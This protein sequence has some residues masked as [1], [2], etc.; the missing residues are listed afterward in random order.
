MVGG[1]TASCFYAFLRTTQGGDLVVDLREEQVEEFAQ[2]F[3]KDCYVDRASI[4]KALQ[5]RGSFNIIHLSSSFKI[6]F[7]PLRTRSFSQQ[8][9]SRRR[10]QALRKDSV[11]SAYVATPEDTVLSKLEW[12]RMGREVSENQWRDVV[13]I[14][15]AQKGRLDVA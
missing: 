4:W 12:Y 14:L 8:E 10:R 3:Q 6:G 5:D 1:S 9:F 7:F 2:T 13:G 11:E 15:K